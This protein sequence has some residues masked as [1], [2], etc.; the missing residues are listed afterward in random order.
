MANERERVEKLGKA[1][2]REVIKILQ[3]LGCRTR[4]SDIAAELPNYGWCFVE[5]KNKEPFSP[6]ATG[7]PYW[8]QGLEIYEYD[9]YTDILKK[10]GM[11]CLFVV[12]GP[13]R[14][15]LAQF[16][17]VLHGEKVYIAGGVT[18]G[19]VM[20]YN[21]IHFIP[22]VELIKK[23]R[24]APPVPTGTTV[25]LKAG[26]ELE[27]LQTSWRQVIEQA[28]EDT[29]RTPVIAILRSAGVKPV[30]AENNTIVIAFRY[31]IHKEKMEMTENLQVAEKIIGNFLGHSCH[32]R[33]QMNKEEE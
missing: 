29:K 11:R 14:E 32:V 2:E 7:P 8:A 4:R 19:Y 3:R 12:R 5:V 30:A 22:L 16:L 18:P 23:G 1:G 28:P 15:W 17:D 20:Y 25:S 26:S 13:H 21:L 6:G 31:P 27:Q 10:K 33:C 9:F 24:E